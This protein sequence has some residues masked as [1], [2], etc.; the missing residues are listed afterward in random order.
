M[1]HTN[2]LCIYMTYNKE[3]KIY[4]YIEKVLKSLKV[5]CSRVYLVC[6][7]KVLKAGLNDS[8]SYVDNIFFRENIGYDSGAFKDALCEFLGWDEV[9]RYD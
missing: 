6:N 1:K 4:P 7:C 5:C 3:N 8:Q 2:R 9:Y